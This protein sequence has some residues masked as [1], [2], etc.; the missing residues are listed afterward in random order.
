VGDT[1]LT[2]E[3]PFVTDPGFGLVNRDQCEPS[4]RRINVSLE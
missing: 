2:P 3:S 4:Q 1:A